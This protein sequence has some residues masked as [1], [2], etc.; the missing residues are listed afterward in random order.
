[1][2][3]LYSLIFIFTAW[4]L[5]ASGKTAAHEESSASNVYTIYLLR[6][7]EKAI[8]KQ[9]NGN[10]PLSEC[11]T[12]RAA[13]LATMFKSINLDA[14]YSTDYVRTQ[15]TAEPVSK[16]KGIALVSYNPRELEEFAKQLINN[17]QNVLVV[18][19]SNNTSVLAG[20]L[21]GQELAHIDESI[22]DRLYQVTIATGEPPVSQLQLLH[23]T[24]SCS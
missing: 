11:G 7:A 2:K 23:Q 9:G 13:S 18:G 4:L 22:Y 8:D 14:I 10:P 6:H 5:F 17:E 24:F 20:Y 21:S 12:Q 19:H 15:M 16:D 1:M 3:L